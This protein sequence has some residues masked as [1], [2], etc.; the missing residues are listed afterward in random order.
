MEIF[1]KQQLGSYLPD[2]APWSSYPLHTLR[3]PSI[4]RNLDDSG[5]LEELVTGLEEYRHRHHGETR[6]LDWHCWQNLTA[7]WRKY[8][9]IEVSDNSNDTSIEKLFTLWEDSSDEK[10]YVIISRI[11]RCNCPFRQEQ[12]G[13]KNYTCGHIIYVLHHVLNCPEPLKWQQAFL[14]KELEAIFRLSTAFEYTLDIG[15][16]F[17]RNTQCVLCFRNV[18]EQGS[19]MHST[20]CGLLVHPDCEKITRTLTPCILHSSALIKMGSSRES[21][22][23]TWPS[24]LSDDQIFSSHPQEPSEDGNYRSESSSDDHHSATNYDE[25]GLSNEQSANRSAVE[26]FEERSRVSLHSPPVASAAFS[27]A[28]SVA[29]KQEDPESPCPSPRR[30]LPSRAAKEA[31]RA[32]PDAYT[33]SPPRKQALIPARPWSPKVSTTPIP[34]PVIPGFPQPQPLPVGGSQPTRRVENPVPSPVVPASVQGRFR[35]SR[36]VGRASPLRAIFTTD[37]CPSPASATPPSVSGVSG[38]AVLPS[39]AEVAR[40]SS[41]SRSPA[42]HPPPVEHNVDSFVSLPIPPAGSTF[43]SISIPV[44]DNASSPIKKKKKKTGPKKKRTATTST[45]TAPTDQ[46]STADGQAGATN[47][48]PTTVT[49]TP[50]HQ[51][52]VDEVEAKKREK[53]KTK[54]FKRLVR[55]EEDSKK[56]KRTKKYVDQELEKLEKRR[57]KVTKKIARLMEMGGDV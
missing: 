18:H 10:F 30:Q 29:I 42:F 26:F 34:L 54:L 57:S 44:A 22:V 35:R 36:A 40:S 25:D 7:R 9:V 20:C 33:G 3:V 53:R 11:P 21:S 16:D 1:S 5:Y 8:R 39:G 27:S 23:D 12:G 13:R 17:A 28:G 38:S 49:G 51:S 55:I 48:S 46:D 45:A 43:A 2:D 32:R 19:H 4:I 50:P 52:N 6:L 41:L 31:T 37:P 14:S 47:T 56:V 15:M 24:R